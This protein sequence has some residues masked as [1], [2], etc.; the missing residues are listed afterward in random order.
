ME[1]IT[2]VDSHTAGEPTRVITEGGPDLGGGSLV[3]RRDRFQRE[4]DR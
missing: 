1:R 2:I 4:F 3:A